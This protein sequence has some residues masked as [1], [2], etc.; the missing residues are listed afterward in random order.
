MPERCCSHC[1]GQMARRANESPSGWTK[2]RFCSHR[3]A[4]LYANAHR[5][6]DLAPEVLIRQRSI[7]DAQ[8]GCWNWRKSKARGRVKVNG[9]AMLAA[10]LAYQTF[11][12][13]LAEGLHVCHRCDNPACVNPQHLFLGTQAENMADMRQKRRNGWNNVKLTESDVEAIRA[14]TDS[15]GALAR[16]YGVVRT[17]IS[18]I[19]N[20]ISW[21]DGALPRSI[22]GKPREAVEPQCADLEAGRASGAGVSG[23]GGEP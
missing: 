16:R 1:A 3:C 4:M 18:N 22:N 15:N 8:T 13:P 17:T 19:R 12:G 7:V 11:V 20:G 6:E 2:R 23:E 9:K 10:R 5:H 14:S 21:R